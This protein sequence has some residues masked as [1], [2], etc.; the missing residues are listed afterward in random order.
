MDVVFV[1]LGEVDEGVDL[2]VG[3]LD[4]VI[5][6]VKMYGYFDVV[7]VD[8]VQCVGQVWLCLVGDIGYQVGGV[9]V[10]VYGKFLK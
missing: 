8:L 10:V 1:W 7:Y 5:V 2:G 3:M 6:S 4:V 9:F